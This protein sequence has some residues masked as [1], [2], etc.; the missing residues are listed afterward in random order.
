MKR[1]Q[2]LGRSHLEVGP[3]R[4]YAAGGLVRRKVSMVMEVDEEFWPEAIALFAIG[5][6]ENKLSAGSGRARQRDASRGSIS[7]SKEADVGETKGSN[8]GP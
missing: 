6:W 3:G 7:E 4:G 8:P 1:H 5:Y 2:G